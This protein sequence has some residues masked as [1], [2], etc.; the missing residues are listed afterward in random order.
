M[1]GLKPAMNSKPASME[2]SS[3][4]LLLTAKLFVLSEYAKL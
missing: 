4:L 1:A 3:I 2:L